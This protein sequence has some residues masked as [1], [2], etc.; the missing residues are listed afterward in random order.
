MADF[1]TALAVVLEQ[2]GGYVNNP[3]DNGGETYRG[4][5]RKSNPS[6]SG[7]SIVDRVRQDNLNLAELNEKLSSN[8]VL[9]SLIESF[10]EQGYWLFD[11]INDQIIANKVLSYSVN[12]GRSRGVKILQTALLHLGNDITVDGSIGP[13]T[14]KTINDS[15]P[16][17]LLGQLKVEGILA[18]VQIVL[19]NISQE[20]FLRGW[21]SRDVS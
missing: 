18:H 14:L 21:I 6:W 11:S 17:R 3:H 20:V 8:A 7:W 10:Y 1:K 2:E 4:I 19:H 5:A 9:T 13:K 16:D 12:F 15:N